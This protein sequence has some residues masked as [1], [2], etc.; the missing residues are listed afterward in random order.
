MARSACPDPSD[1]LPPW[2][3]FPDPGAWTDWI[4]PD[5]SRWFNAVW[6]PY[7][8]SLSIPRKM[9]YEKRWRIS[10]SCFSL[11]LYWIWSCVN[12]T[13][14]A[15]TGITDTVAERRL[16]R[17]VL[18]L[19]GIKH[20]GLYPAAPFPLLPMDEYALPPPWLCMYSEED[21]LILVLRY[22]LQHSFF[23][24]IWLP[25]WQTLD[26]AQRPAYLA[27]WPR[28]PPWEKFLKNAGECG[29]FV[30]HQDVD[31]QSDASR[32]LIWASADLACKNS[33]A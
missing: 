11:L 5:A 6:W 33:G 23:N 31:L 19:R 15:Y 26:E 18:R 27:R 9:A 28:N 16:H 13:N 12:R 21:N 2:I 1:P 17:W 14:R 25:F 3:A 22:S 8:Q 24:E 7:W 20:D 10:G 29:L 30:P 4:R 32:Q